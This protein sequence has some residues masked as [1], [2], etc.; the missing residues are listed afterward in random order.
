MFGSTLKLLA[1]A[2]VAVGV[3]APA[4]HGSTELSPAQ[5]S[6]LGAR[7]EAVGFTA[8]SRYLV[9]RGSSADTATLA[10][11]SEAKGYRALVRYQEQRAVTAE[12]VR[13]SASQF[14]WSD[15]LAGAG[16]TAGVFL[17]GA[18]AALMFRRRHVPT[19]IRE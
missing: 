15:A 5:I 4:A 6:R 2:I 3:A 17:L 14:A 16:F 19:R 10:A 13:S 12:P 7:T 11:R 1:V 9:D 18:A 8:I